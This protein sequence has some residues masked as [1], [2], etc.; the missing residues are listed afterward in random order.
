MKK[1]TLF[2]VFIGMMVLQSCEVT[3]VYDNTDN[4][5]R[6]EVFEVTTSFNSSNNY[7][8]LVEFNPPIYSSDSV[9]VYHLYDTVNGQD[10]WK[11]MPQTY[12]FNDGGALDFNFDFSRF[13]VNLFL[14]A[15]FS[16]NT[17]PSSWTQ[18]Q[19]FRIVI[20][21]DGFAKTINKNNIDSVMS[22]L[23]VDKSEVKKIN[24]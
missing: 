4:G 16:L 17:L 14:S 5:P 15:N 1:I 21:P 23:K 6:N 19:T 11:L 7:S 10:I 13:N 2:L 8:S 3:E 18:N 22:A 9:L 12:Y 20:I 24:L